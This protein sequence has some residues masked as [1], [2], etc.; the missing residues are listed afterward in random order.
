MR[1]RPERALGSHNEWVILIYRLVKCRA[2]VC[3]T[4][5]LF[6]PLQSYGPYRPVDLPLI[7]S[8]VDFAFAPPASP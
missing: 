3:T 6:A 8:A 7:S 5:A 4:H 2:L 1:R